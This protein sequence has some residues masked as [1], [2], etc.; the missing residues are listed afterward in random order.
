MTLYKHLF[1]IGFLFLKRNKIN[2]IIDRDNIA[3][4]RCKYMRNIQQ[5]REDKYKMYYLDETLANGGYTTS[6]VWADT[7]VGAF[8]SGL[9]TGIKKKHHWKRKMFNYSSHWK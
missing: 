3:L 8:L 7:T 2:A 5:Y 6:K 9:T 4:W 1:E